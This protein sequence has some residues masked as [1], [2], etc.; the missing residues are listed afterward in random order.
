MQEI[1]K[2]VTKKLL[3]FN[4]IAQPGQTKNIFIKT[5]DCKVVSLQMKI[6]TV[7]EIN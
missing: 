1:D 3:A 6:K 7:V 2:K 4:A 5:Y